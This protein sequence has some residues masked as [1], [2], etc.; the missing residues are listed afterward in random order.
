MDA[1]V[2]LFI[3]LLIVGCIL[4]LLLWLVKAAPIPE[5]FKTWLWFAVIALAVLILI[6]YVLLP[7]AGS[8]PNLHL[9]R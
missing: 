2:H 7:L 4:G 9:G 5:P 1:L 8:P 6:L 3:Y